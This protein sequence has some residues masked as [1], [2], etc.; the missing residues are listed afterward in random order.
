[1]EPGDADTGSEPDQADER[2]AHESDQAEEM[3]A[4]GST[5]SSE[6]EEEQQFDITLAAYHSVSDSIW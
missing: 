2:L 1:M 3:L 6:D 5:G 4:S